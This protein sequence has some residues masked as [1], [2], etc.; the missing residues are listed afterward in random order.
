MVITTGGT[1][2]VRIEQI[3]LQS[4]Q[5]NLEASGML[6]VNLGDPLTALRVDLQVRE[7]EEYDQLLQTLGFAANGKKGRAAIPVD[8]A[9]CDGV[10]RDGAGRGRG[11]GFE[12][13]SAGY[14]WRRSWARRWMR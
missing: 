11:S 2:V 8:V 12:G 7:L 14:R 10:Q 4:P 1:E 5:S 6:G 9:R 13:A 3:T